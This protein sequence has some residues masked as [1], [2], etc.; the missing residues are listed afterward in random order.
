MVVDGAFVDC[1]VADKYFEL[2]EDRKIRGYL[3]QEKNIGGKKE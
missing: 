2:L 1:M 3:Y